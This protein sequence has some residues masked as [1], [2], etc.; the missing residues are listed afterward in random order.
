MA[1]VVTLLGLMFLTWG[2]AVWASF[3]EDGGTEIRH[4][5]D[6]VGHLRKV[7]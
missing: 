3:T 7:A 5:Q 4:T 6:R 1:A 2:V